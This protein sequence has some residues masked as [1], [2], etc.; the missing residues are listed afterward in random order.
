MEIEI[1]TDR[2]FI[3]IGGN[4]VSIV[5]VDEDPPKLRLAS[6]SGLYLG[7]ISFGRLRP[8]GRQ[9]ELVLISGKQD[10]RTRNDPNNY[11]GEI[12]ISIRDGANPN[13]DAGMNQVMERVG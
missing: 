5:S 1:P 10:E 6:P 12:T 7:C 9:E 4:E 3:H 11:S 8:D 13:A 2:G